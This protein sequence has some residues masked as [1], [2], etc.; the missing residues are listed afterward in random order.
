[1]KDPPPFKL[2]SLKS[3]TNTD[4]SYALT[5]KPSRPIV[6]L[7]RHA[8]FLGVFLCHLTPFFVYN[9]HLGNKFYNF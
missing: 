4:C 2:F 7:A 5:G 6:V 9:T 3:Q 8:T 1:M